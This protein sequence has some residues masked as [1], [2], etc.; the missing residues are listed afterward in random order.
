MI[1]FSVPRWYVMRDLKRCN[2]KRRGFIEL[3]ENGYEVFT[4]MME[5]IVVKNGRRIRKQE[6]VISDLLFVYSSKSRLDMTVA[7]IPTLQYR[8]YRGHTIDDPMVV[9]EEDMRRFI[10]A[11]SRS[12]THRYYLTGEIRPEMYGKM[13]RVVGGTFDGLTGRL[14]SIRGSRKKRLIVEIPDFI[15]AAVEIQPE[16]I[17]YL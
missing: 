3:L 1:D 9:R 12:D 8:Y 17:Q 10:E 5:R 4:P 14:L 6:P 13:I 7:R 2:A 15:V 11:V 16:F